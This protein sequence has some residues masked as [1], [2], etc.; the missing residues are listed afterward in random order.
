MNLANGQ[1]KM[2]LPL[3]R[4]LKYLT[5]VQSSWVGLPLATEIFSLFLA[6]DMI[7]GMTPSY[8]GCPEGAYRV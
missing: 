4:W 2:S 5:G 1:C 3:A 8:A 7:T 6:K